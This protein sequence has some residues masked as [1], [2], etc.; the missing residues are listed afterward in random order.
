MGR[1]KQLE[2]E[3]ET[4]EVSA[5]F[6]LAIL[7]VVVTI[8]IAAVLSYWASS[9]GAR[10]TSGVDEC[11]RAQL[12]LYSGNYDNSTRTLFMYLDNPQSV[13]LSHLTLYLF[14]SGDEMIEKPLEGVLKANSIKAFNLTDVDGN[15]RKGV[16]KT[17]C[18]GVQIEFVLSS[19]GLHQV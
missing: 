19:D 11:A 14:Y 18:P 13:D 10:S 4:K 5:P 15:F 16:I 7:L 9:M 12:R 2:W 3:E 17:E 1:Y 8:L 6:S